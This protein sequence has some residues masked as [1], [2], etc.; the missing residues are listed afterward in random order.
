[1]NFQLANSEEFIDGEF[2]GVL[3]EILVRCNNVLYIRG[4]DGASAAAAASVEA[5]AG[6]AAAWCAAVAPLRRALHSTT[7]EK[8]NRDAAAPYRS[9]IQSRFTYPKRR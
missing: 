3:G 2:A 7:L 9:T 4:T 8:K 6:D 1:M 5:G